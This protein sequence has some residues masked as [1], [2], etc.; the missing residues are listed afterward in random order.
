MAGVG[1]PPRDRRSHPRGGHRDRRADQAGADDRDAFR[2]GRGHRAATPR[3]RGT[4]E[5][6]G[7]GFARCG[8][9]PGAGS[10]TASD[11]ATGISRAHISGTRPRPIR[12]AASA[13]NADRRSSVT[14]NRTLIRSSGSIAFRSSTRREQSLRRVEHDLGVVVDHDDGTTGGTNLHDEFP[15]RRTA[16]RSDKAT[17]RWPV[18][19]SG[20]PRASARG[21]HP[22]P[23]SPAS[24][25]RRAAAPA[26][27]RAGPPRRAAGEPR[28]CGP[29]S[30]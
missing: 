22:A 4:R 14:V 23:G 3:R 2:R 26:A 25:D 19:E 17:C 30:W 10:R 13:G 16:P 1:V 5:R 11:P 8:S 24:R 27:P 7:R 21:A 12:R 18:R 6:S 28:A 15:P 20:S 9:G 29:P